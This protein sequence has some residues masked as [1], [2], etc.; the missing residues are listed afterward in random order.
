MS[1]FLISFLWIY[2]FPPLKDVV[3]LHPS[4]QLLLPDK[5]SLGRDAIYFCPMLHKMKMVLMHITKSW[6][7]FHLAPTL[8][9]Q[10]NI[11]SKGW[12][13]TQIHHSSLTWRSKHW[14]LARSCSCPGEDRSLLQDFLSVNSFTIILPA[15]PNIDQSNTF[16]SLPN[17]SNSNSLSRF[18]NCG[19]VGFNTHNPGYLEFYSHF[20]SRNPYKGKLH[21]WMSISWNKPPVLA[22]AVAQLI[23]MRGRDLSSHQDPFP[24]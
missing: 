23:C 22:A 6:T 17:I 9:S 4:H 8:F 18:R 16:Y 7:G 11:V 14:G 24:K 2:L 1:G 13:G 12:V 19:K 21:F 10:F 15:H 5:S 20:Q 3:L